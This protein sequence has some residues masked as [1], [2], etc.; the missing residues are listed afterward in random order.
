M[1]TKHDQQNH[2]LHY[3]KRNNYITLDDLK[4]MA[5]DREHFFELVYLGH[6]VEVKPDTFEIPKRVKKEVNNLNLFQ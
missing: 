4:N 1:T 6:L 5:V 3:A 2:I